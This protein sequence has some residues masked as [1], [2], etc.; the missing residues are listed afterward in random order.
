MKPLQRD[1]EIVTAEDDQEFLARLQLT[2]NRA[3]S[4]G[5]TVREHASM[6]LSLRHSSVHLKDEG[7]TPVLTRNANT[8]GMGAGSAGPQTP[9]MPGRPRNQPV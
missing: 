7:G 3:A 2:L 8:M 6:I 1:N 5:R 4:P 9:A